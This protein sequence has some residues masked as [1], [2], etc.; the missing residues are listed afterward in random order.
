MRSRTATVHERERIDEMRALR[1]FEAGP[2]SGDEAVVADTHDEVG[3][4]GVTLMHDGSVRPSD[5]GGG[6]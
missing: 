4:S 5:S 2:G 1:G 3:A 6:S